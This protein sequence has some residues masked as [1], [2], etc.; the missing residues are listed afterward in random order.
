ML[1][2][3]QIFFINGKA[4]QLWGENLET[5]DGDIYISLEGETV[6]KFKLNNIAGY[7]L[8]GEQEHEDD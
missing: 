2:L 5:Y 8:A 6:A 3:F 7:V 1:Y 4:I